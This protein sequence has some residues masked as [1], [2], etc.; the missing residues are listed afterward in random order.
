MSKASQLK[1]RAEARGKIIKGDSTEIKTVI[2][3]LQNGGTCNF[4][5]EKGEIKRPDHTVILTIIGDGN[6]TTINTDKC[7]EKI[8]ELFQ[9]VRPRAKISQGDK[10]YEYK[11]TW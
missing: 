8:L 3:A 2:E 10:Y 9:R 11:V 5:A 7:P 1:K 6:Y 4:P